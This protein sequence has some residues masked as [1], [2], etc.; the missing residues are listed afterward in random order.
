[1]LLIKFIS[2][3]KYIF[4]IEIIIRVY[5]HGNLSVSRLG[6]LLLDLSMSQ[7]LVVFTHAMPQYGSND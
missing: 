2:S 5:D 6:K 4:T 7:R 3:I 1:M